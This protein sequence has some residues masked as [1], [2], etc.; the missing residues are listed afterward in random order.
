MNDSKKPATP[1][2]E[3]RNIPWKLIG[4]MVSALVI[5]LFV[6]QN[7]TRM[8]VNFLFFEVN[9]RQW[10]NLLVAVALGVIADRSFIGMRKLRRK[11]D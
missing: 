1:A 8:N 11:G 10:V 5:V 9:S 3:S 2:P 7:R 6:L 4:F